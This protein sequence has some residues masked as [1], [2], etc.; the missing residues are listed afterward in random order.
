M[1]EGGRDDLDGVDGG[2]LGGNKAGSIGEHEFGC[3]VFND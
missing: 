3:G 1:R 2:G